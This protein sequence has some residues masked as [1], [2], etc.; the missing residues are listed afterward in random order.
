MYTKAFCSSRRSPFSGSRRSGDSSGSDRPLEAP[1]RPVPKASVQ[2]VPGPPPPPSFVGAMLRRRRKPIPSLHPRRAIFVAHA[3]DLNTLANHGWLPRD[4]VA[5]PGQ[6]ITAVQDALVERPPTTG[7]DPPAPAIVGGLNNHGTFEGDA[8]MTRADAFFGDNHSFN[9]ALFFE[10]L[11]QNFSMIYGNGFFN[12]TV[13]AE[14]R[15]HRIQESISNNPP[16]EM[17][18]FRHSTAYAEASFPATFFVDGRKTGAEFGQ[19]DMATAESFFKDA[20]FP[21]DFHRPAAPVDGLEKNVNG[22]NTFEV[23][24]SIGSAIDP[25]G[26]YQD[27]STSK[28]RVSTPTRLG[29]GCEQIFPYGQE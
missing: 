28:S 9:P 25:C 23:D 6:I 26:F 27:S 2:N 19:L 7:P 18:G 16:F 3:L 1:V 8:S 24:T 12:R 10:Q 11:V 15:Y 17:L 13:A 4:G 22:V 21:V 29:G 20:H 5:T 14:L